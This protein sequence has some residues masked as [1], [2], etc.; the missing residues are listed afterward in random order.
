MSEVDAIVIGAGVVGLACAAE[1]AAQGR[2]VCL[3]ERHG[4]PGLDTSTH[5]SGVIHAGIYYPPGTLKAKLCVEG[6]R[7]M[8]DFCAQPGVPHARCGKLIVAPIET[9]DTSELEALYAR[10]LA[11]GVEDL[12]MV[13]AA[14]VTKR[15]PHGRD[16]GALLSGSPR[17]VEHE[18]FVKALKQVC[19]ARDVMLVVGSA[20]VGADRDGDRLSV[21]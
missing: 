11:N 1:I 13:D 12:S 3:L 6:K 21:R 18:A 19:D 15:E 5:N 14:Y 17:I 8:Y 9:N 4:K 7:L 16:K 2:S 20:V 10:G